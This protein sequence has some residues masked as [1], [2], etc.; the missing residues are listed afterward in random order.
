MDHR[1]RAEIDAKID[2]EIAQFDP[3]RRGHG[4]SDWNEATLA[5]F[6]TARISPD[7]IE[8]NLPG[9]VTDFAYAVTKSNGNYRVVYLPWLGLFSLAVESKFGPVDIN[10]H[11]GAI[12]CFDSV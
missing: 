1:E 7:T 3:A 9:G 5:A 2:T 11:G 8:I 10:V 12:D 4:I 6:Q